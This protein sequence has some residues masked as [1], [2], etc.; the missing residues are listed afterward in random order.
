VSCLTGATPDPTAKLDDLNRLNSIL[1]SVFGDVRRIL[2]A[3]GF[4]HD[5]ATVANIFSMKPDTV[6]K[7][8]A[9]PRTRIAS[10]E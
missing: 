5:S 7:R 6:S 1:A 8:I 3:I 9:R 2:L 4:D 10:V